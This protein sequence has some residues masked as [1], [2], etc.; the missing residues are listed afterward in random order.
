MKKRS[1]DKTKN[2][3]FNLKYHKTKQINIP[4]TKDLL[5][6]FAR[7]EFSHRKQAKKMRKHLRR[8]E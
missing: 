7:G 6:K 2:I 3:R 8:L 5:G 1:I 4:R